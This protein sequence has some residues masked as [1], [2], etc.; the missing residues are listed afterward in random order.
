M[1]RTA[2]I[3]HTGFVG[4]TLARSGGFTD[5]YNSSNIEDIAGRRYD[6]AICAGAPGVKWLANKEPANDRAAIAKLTR[7][8]ER[9]SIDELILISTIDVYPDAS[10]GADET[11]VIDPS[12]N[13]AYGAHRF[14][15][16]QWCSASFATCRIAR[17][18]ALFGAGLRK[19][20]LFDL[21]NDKGTE[22]INPLARFQWY[23]MARLAGDLDIMRERDLTLVNLFGEAV[24]MG[25]IRDL[26]FPDAQLG[27]ATQP[28]PAYD[29]R[30]R[31]SDV[32]GGPAGYVMDAATVLQAM[33]TFVNEQR[34]AVSHG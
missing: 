13:H 17:L 19:N 26:F 34:Q 18:P 2:L 30:T 16:E 3:G 33:A 6:R 7:S 9:A 31:Y 20:A 12:I 21:L 22:A 27:P 11:A 28:A 15:L 4:G 5:L 8:L 29:L 32:F 25:E 14:E 24:A 1:E 10:S 23:P